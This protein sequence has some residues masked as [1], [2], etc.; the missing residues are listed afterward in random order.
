MLHGDQPQDLEER[1]QRADA[2]YQDKLKAILEPEY[3]NKFIA[4]EP[5][6]GEY[7]VAD[8]TGNAM[9]AMHSRFPTQPLLL[10]K[11]GPEPEYDLAARIFASDMRASNQTK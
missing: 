11:I 4:I 3:N 10:K 6:S 2:L 9:R 1:M 5:D 7:A 8:S